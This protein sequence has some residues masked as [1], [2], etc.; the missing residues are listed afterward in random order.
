[1][2]EEIGMP[3]LQNKKDAKINFTVVKA[4]ALLTTSKIWKL[5][6]PFPFSSISYVC[7]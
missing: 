7:V 5:P 3:F 4:I 2:F 6:H 1:M